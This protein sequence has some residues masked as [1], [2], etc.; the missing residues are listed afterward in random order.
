MTDTTRH[1]TTRPAGVTMTTLDSPAATTVGPDEPPVQHRWRSLVDGRGGT[2]GPG[3]R[4]DRVDALD[5]PTAPLGADAPA[6]VFSAARA[7]THI[8]TI[9]EDPRPIGSAEHAEARAYLL[10]Q[11]A[12][13]GW[14]TEV[15]Q[16]VGR[17][18]FG[19]DGTQNL[20]AVANV[21]ATKPGS[22]ANRYRPAHRALRHCRGITGCRRRRHRRR[23]AAGDRE[24]AQHGRRRPERRHDPADRRRGARFARRGGIPP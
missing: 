23:G 16:T 6:E 1:P 11:L 4:R 2:C 12:S 15:Q 17:F 9:A 14:R 20:A 21:I 18:D 24:G 5:G 8:E 19:A 13:L 10:E 3:A 7:M 22:D